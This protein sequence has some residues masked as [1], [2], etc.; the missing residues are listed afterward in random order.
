MRPELVA[1]LRI[2][3]ERGL[4]EKEDL[5]RVQKSA[6]N[7]QPPLHA[8]GELLHLI[9]APIPQLEE[10]Q[11]FL[12]PLAAN[13]VRHMVEHAV[14][15]HVFPGRQIAVE[16]GILKHDPEALARLVLLRLRV[17]PVEFNGAAG[18]LQQRG[19][20]FDGGGF[21]CPVGPE[22]GKDL[23]LRH[24]ERDIVHGGKRAKG[25]HKVLHLDH[26]STSSSNT[27]RFS[28]VLSTQ[29]CGLWISY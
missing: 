15:F 22:K 6:R 1:A 10:L 20:H 23:A 3:A 11:Q 4:V 13:F 26:G 5:R 25:L 14:D 24:V 12:G 16:A 28:I 2:E 7:L 27:E 17:E 19:Q 8:A 29:A 21:A 9:F 18:G